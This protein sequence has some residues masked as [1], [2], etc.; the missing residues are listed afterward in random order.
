M[1]WSISWVAVQGKPAAQVLSELEFE[2]LCNPRTDDNTCVLGASL[3]SGWYLVYIDDSWHEQLTPRVLEKLSRGGASVLHCVVEEAQRVSSACLYYDGEP[4]WLVLHDGEMSTDHL[5][6]AGAAPPE[7]DAL[8]AQAREP[9][10]RPRSSYHIP[11]S[12]AGML[13]GFD[14]EHPDTLPAFVE[15]TEVI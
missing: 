3:D 15:L 6:V 8:L 1:M 7:L 12:L 13:C 4:V 5:D 9:Q 14:H 2:A 10:P 11:I